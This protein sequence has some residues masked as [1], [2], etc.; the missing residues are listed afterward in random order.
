MIIDEISLVSRKMHVQINQRLTEILETTTET[1]FSGLPVIVCRDLHQLPQV[2]PPAIY[3]RCDDNLSLKSRNG[4]YLWN[5]FEIAELKEV[6]RQ[7]GDMLLIYK[8]N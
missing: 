3:A 5:L 2:N 7:R 1:P 8:Q 4:L 6:M